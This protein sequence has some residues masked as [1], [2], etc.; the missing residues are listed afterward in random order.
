MNDRRYPAAAAH[1]WMVRENMAPHPGGKA[2][3]DKS[4]YAVTGLTAEQATAAR[5]AQLIRGHGKTEAR[6]HVRDVTFTEDLTAAHR[7]RSGRPEPWSRPG[8]R[9]C[10]L[11]LPGPTTSGTALMGT[12]VR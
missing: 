7:D 6:H 12:S 11:N 4:V 5:L 3:K 10:W 2:R 8:S 1:Y 9:A